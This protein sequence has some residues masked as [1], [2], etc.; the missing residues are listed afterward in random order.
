MRLALLVIFV[1]VLSGCD[2]ESMGPEEVYMTYVARS[3]EGLSF[4]EELVFWSE[5]KL[6]QLEERLE[7]LMKRSGRT[8]DEAIGLY[9]DISKRTAECTTLELLSKGIVGNTASMV[10]AATDTCG[11]AT[12][13]THNV[14]LVLEDEW[15]LDEV[16][17]VIQ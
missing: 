12:A 6:S 15:K 9:M 8:R 5:D 2:S 7:S 11:E 1:M 13:S 16:E 14:Q 3:A 10:F 4:D 17:I